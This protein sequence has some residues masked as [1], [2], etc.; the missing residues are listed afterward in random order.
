[1]KG[2]FGGTQ[3]GPDGTASWNGDGPYFS[4][5]GF[6]FDPSSGLTYTMN[7]TGAVIYE[8]LRE[9]RGVADI[10]RA[11]TDRFEVDEVVARADLQDFVQQM[12]DLGLQ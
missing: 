5:G 3:M 9:G 12:R 10:V 2:L 8:M 4:R 11:L 7:T 1:M 6:L